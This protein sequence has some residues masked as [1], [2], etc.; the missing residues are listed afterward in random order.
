MNLLKEASSFIKNTDIP[1]YIVDLLFQILIFFFFF[2]IFCVLEQ[3]EANIHYAE[4][5]L[6]NLSERLLMLCMPVV[7]TFILF[8]LCLTLCIAIF[9][10]KKMLINTISLVVLVLFVVLMTVC[11][12]GD[13]ESL[14]IVIFSELPFVVNIIIWHFIFPEKYYD[15]KIFILLALNFF[16]GLVVGGMTAVFGSFNS[17]AAIP[18]WSTSILYVI[19]CAWRKKSEVKRESEKN[20]KELMGEKDSNQLQ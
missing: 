3:V 16:V 18:I 13:I 17:F 6:Y 8:S 9:K 5:D 12:I 15:A 14:V 1:S 7:A 19:W 10:R 2:S 4:H 20:F 11:A